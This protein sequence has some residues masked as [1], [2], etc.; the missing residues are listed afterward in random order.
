MAYN[1]YFPSVS[2]VYMVKL[3]RT[4]NR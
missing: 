4:I 3:G 1:A 2:S